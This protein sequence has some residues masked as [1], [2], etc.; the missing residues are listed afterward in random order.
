MRTALR[1]IGVLF[2]RNCSVPDK[3]VIVDLF[4]YRRLGK[5][6]DLL[7]KECGFARSVRDFFEYSWDFLQKDSPCIV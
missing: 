1:E 3:E 4:E 7:W 2:Q 6:R 5:H